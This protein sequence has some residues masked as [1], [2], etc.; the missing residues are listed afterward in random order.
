[1]FVWER[2]ADVEKCF[3]KYQLVAF[4]YNPIKKYRKKNKNTLSA[5]EGALLQFRLVWQCLFSVL[6]IVYNNF[7]IT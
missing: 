2:I 5:F 4:A 3:F 7:S 6:L 1:M